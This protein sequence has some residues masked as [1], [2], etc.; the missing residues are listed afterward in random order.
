MPQKDWFIHIEGQSF[1]PL[2]T[3][4]VNIMLRQGR[5]QI[6]DFAWYRGLTRWQRLGEFEVFSTHVP[7]Y[8]V[9]PV[10][11]APRAQE[12][13]PSTTPNKRV[14]SLAPAKVLRM[15]PVSVEA[16]PAHPVGRGNVAVAAKAAPEA[17]P[18]R[19]A[20]P[21]PVAVAAPEPVSMPAPASA[22]AE[23]PAA[24]AANALAPKSKFRVQPR[25][26]F[27]GK[28]HVDKFGIFGVKDISVGGLL[29]D[30]KEPIP[31]G[32][33][34]R[35]GLESQDLEKRIDMTGVVVRLIEGKDGMTGIGVEFTRINP[36]HKR[37]LQEYVNSKLSSEG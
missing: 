23:T 15:T 6:S 33:P 18:M 11:E 2:S 5:L 17:V 31:V 10:P 3:D 37:I 26:S 13:A 21:A 30:A 20:K 14:F 19:K 1:G 16:P 4:V 27:G 34:L 29:F 36:A 35:F 32:T 9:V 24:A 12:S 7:P 25:V 8:P 28:L 22:P